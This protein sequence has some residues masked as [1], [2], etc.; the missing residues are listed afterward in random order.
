MSALGLKAHTVFH[1]IDKEGSFYLVTC[2]EP[3]FSSYFYEQMF[4]DVYTLVPFSLFAD[5]FLQCYHC[6]WIC[7]I[8][9]TPYQ[10][11]PST[12][13][14][15]CCQSCS[16]RMHWPQEAQR[17]FSCSKSNKQKL[18]QISTLNLKGPFKIL[19]TLSL[20]GVIIK[21]MLIEKSQRTD[22]YKGTLETI[23]STLFIFPMGKPRHRAETSF[24]HGGRTEVKNPGP[25]ISQTS[26]HST[27]IPTASC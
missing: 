14:F 1:T 10:L 11:F 18:W 9:K 5:L 8:N 12:M 23:L 2:P 13:V 25:Q 27:A 21:Y 16:R 22:G 15:A 7:G 4:A 20:N 19:S 24:D 17:L 3:C 6:Q 26:P